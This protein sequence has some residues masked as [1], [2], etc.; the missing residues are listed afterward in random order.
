MGNAI[1]KVTGTIFGTQSAPKTPDYYGLADATAKSNLAA[2]TNVADINRVNQIGPTGSQTW[3]MRPGADPNNPQAGDYI[4]T[5]SLSPEQQALYNSQTATQQGMA[6]LARA[7]VSTLGGSGIGGKLDTS[8][9][10]PGFTGDVSKTADQFSADRQAISDALYNQQTKYLG[11]QF[12]REDEATRTRL[13]NQGLEEGSAGYQ[14]A[15]RD[16]DRR[17]NEAYVSAANNATTGS[18]AAQK[19]MQD[20]LL[21]AAQTQQNVSSQGA[22]SQIQQRAAPLNELS[23]MLEGGQ[24]TMPQFQAYGNAANVSGTDYTGAGRDT[25]TSALTNVQYNNKQNAD[26]MKQVAQLLAML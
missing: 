11:D 7:G 2:A 23:A 19:A 22:A 1:N 3:S 10:A 5:T 4:V 25:Y 9:F 12:G 21:A 18:I 20:A 16:Q 15:M 8:T 24:V 6:D 17:Q 26:N 13:L 14:A